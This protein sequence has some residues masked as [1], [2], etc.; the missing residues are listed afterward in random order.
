MSL[1]TQGADHRV[2]PHSSTGTNEIYEFG[3]FAI[4]VAERV[5]RRQDRIVPLP[6]K[7]FDTLLVL[8]Q[9]GG[10]VVEKEALIRAV[11]PVSFVE[12]GN[13]A[14]NIFTLRKTLGQLPDE[15]Q[16]IQT[17]PK[18]GYRLVVPPVA[19]GAG[20]PSPEGA[21]APRAEPG[22]ASSKISYLFA[23]GIALASLLIAARWVWPRR[24]SLVPAGRFTLLTVP[25]NIAYGVI[26]PD[27]RHIAYVSRDAD[28]QSLWVR[29]TAG[30]GAGS[31]LPGPLPGHFWGVSYSPDEEFLYYAFEDEMRPVGGTLFRIPCRGGDA[32][33][34]FEHVSAAPAFSPDGRRMVFKRYDPNGRGYLLTATALGTGI[35]IVAQ[36]DAVNAFNNYQWAADGRS[37]DYVEG[38]RYPDGTNWSTLTLPTAGGPARLAMKLPVKRLRSVNWLNQSEI[39][40][41]IADEESGL[42]Q[43]WRLGAGGLARRLTNDISNYSQIGM[44]ADGRTV[45]ANSLETHDSIWTV[46]AVETGRTEPIR[47]SLPTGSYDGPVWTPDGHVVF[48]GQSNLWLAT[49]DGVSRE[50]LIPNKVI[51]SEPVLSADDRLV[52]F[53]LLRQGL[54]NL[55]RTGTDGRN[56]RQVTSGRFDCHPALS[57]DGKWVAYASEVPGQPALWKAPLEGTGSPVKLADAEGADLAISPD[58]KLLAYFSD[59]PQIEVRS[60]QD[61]SLVRKMAA[62]GG[63]FSLHWRSDGKALAYACH[64]DRAAQLWRQPIIGGPAVRIGELLPGDV[65][66]LDWS[67]DETRIVFLRREIKVDLA[68]ITNPR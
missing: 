43:I 21:A 17:V 36:S 67:H 61:G 10:R 37:I 53:V 57:P 32:Q 12:E 22:R 27:G 44:T 28:G 66:E 16:Y 34:L 56:L 54:R 11:W 13:L 50:P 35:K 15:G 24:D 7:C 33:K 63:A 46:P 8:A 62:P 48:V 55:W 18:R 47:M 9:H 64:S 58:G 29:E 65:E 2:N 5:L 51:A 30:V 23:A 68:L 14:Q 20:M 1:E 25:N 6:P 59:L 31:R 19:A 26:S 60:F 52:V 3:P 4:S 40:G 41:L 45:L 38:A 39:L 42:F 49:A